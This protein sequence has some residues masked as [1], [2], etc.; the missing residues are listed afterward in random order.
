MPPRRRCKLTSKEF[1]GEAQM[2]PSWMNTGDVA[3]VNYS[4]ANILA[5]RLRRRHPLPNQQLRLHLAHQLYVQT[6]VWLM[7]TAMSS[8]V[9]DR[10]E[11]NANA[12]LRL[13]PSAQQVLA[14]FQRICFR[15]DV[16]IVCTGLATCSGFATSILQYCRSPTNGQSEHINAQHQCICSPNCNQQH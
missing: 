1:K 14:V 4:S 11:A 10:I 15:N 6:T 13:A 16:V 12:L 8:H 2:V 7:F 9:Q 5:H 3:S